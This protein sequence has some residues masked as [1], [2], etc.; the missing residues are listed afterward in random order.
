MNIPRTWQTKTTFTQILIDSNHSYA[1][2]HESSA[3]RAPCENK[4]LNCCFYPPYTF[5]CFFFFRSSHSFRQVF[6]SRLCRGLCLQVWRSAISPPPSAPRGEPGPRCAPRCQ[7]CPALVAPECPAPRSHV[8]AGS[9]ACAPARPSPTRA[10]S[11]ACRRYPREGWGNRCDSL[12]PPPR[13][14]PPPPPPRPSLR[15]PSVRPRCTHSAADL[16][17]C[18]ATCAGQ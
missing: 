15:R 4:K 7:V 16:L 5:F 18:R 17:A 3:E 12:P 14:G 6:T 8:H 11:I 13:R 9:R 2:R 1:S 10:R